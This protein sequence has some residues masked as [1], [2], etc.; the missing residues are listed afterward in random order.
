FADALAEIEKYYGLTTTPDMA[1]TLT[2][3]EL[4]SLQAAYDLSMTPAA[5]Q[6]IGDQEKYLYGG[7]EPLSMAVSHIINNK[8][9]LS[10]TSYA[11]TGLQ[12]PI[13]AYGVNADLYNGMYDNTDLFTKTMAA[14]GLTIAQ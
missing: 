5:D 1:L 3:A 7:Y 12:I 4:A 8:A 9:G 6:Q 2:D 14:M 11:H 10:Y 13:Y